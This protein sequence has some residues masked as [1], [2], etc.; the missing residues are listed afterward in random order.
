MEFV[1]YT[2]PGQAMMHHW[3]ESAKPSAKS[4]TATAPASRGN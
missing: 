2:G 1:V 4:G 3:V